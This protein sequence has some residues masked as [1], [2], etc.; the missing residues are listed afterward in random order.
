MEN[1]DLNGFDL[2][3]NISLTLLI[4]FIIKRPLSLTIHPSAG[5]P[6][7]HLRTVAKGFGGLCAHFRT[8]VIFGAARAFF[9][10]VGPIIGNYCVILHFNRNKRYA[11]DAFGTT[12]GREAEP[13]RPDV[14]DG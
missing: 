8:K 1:G 6:A 9:S 10:N 5:H 3:G 13:Y 2:K 4:I 11:Y 7:I 12:A 14:S